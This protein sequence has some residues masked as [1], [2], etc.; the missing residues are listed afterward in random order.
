MD[1]NELNDVA[2]KTLAERRP[3]RVRCCMASGC[4]SSNAKGVKEA[5]DAAACGSEDI[6]VLRVGCMGHCSLGPLVTVETAPEHSTGA[7]GEDII[8]SSGKEH[9]AV[10]YERVT[11]QLAPS[12]I[13]AVRGEPCE[14]KTADMS[15]PFFAEQRKVV[16]EKSGRIDPESIEDYIAEGGYRALHRAIFEM[17]PEEVIRTVT[18]SGLRGRGGAGYP[19]GLKWATVAKSPAGRR[20]VVCNADEGYPG[21]FMNRSVLESD[22]HLV[23]EGMAIAAYAVGANQGFVY[24]RGEYP[25]AIRRMQTAIKHARHH[26][27]LGTQVFESGF[28]FRI[29]IR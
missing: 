29:D 21:A 10:M 18:D 25:L 13:G 15:H 11:P 24:C 19:T 4:L 20:F 6:D 28:D 26:G 2:E 3:V 12:I 16:C 17:S 5:L 7:F 1:M 9:T 27:L 23:L 8:S 14:I 22:P